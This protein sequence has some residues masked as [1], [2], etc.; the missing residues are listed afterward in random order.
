MMCHCCAMAAHAYGPFGHFRDCFVPMVQILL[1][2]IRFPTT[3][4]AVKEPRKLD[5]LHRRGANEE[6]D[7]GQFNLC[8]KLIGDR[9]GVALDCWLCKWMWWLMF[10]AAVCEVL[11]EV[12]H[13]SLAA[14]TAAALAI[15]ALAIPAG[16]CLRVSVLTKLRTVAGVWWYILSINTG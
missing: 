4:N 15:L 12:F 3:T 16:L 13:D 11:A 1:K 14:R 6:Q 10:F 9:A 8:S 5:D 7:A 2:S